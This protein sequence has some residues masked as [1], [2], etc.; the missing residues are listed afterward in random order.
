MSSDAQIQLVG[1]GGNDANIAEVDP[2]FCAQRTSLRP[3]EYAPLNG[4]LGGHFRAAFTYSNTAAKPA[5]TSPIFSLRNIDQQ[6]LLVIKRVQLWLAC[7]T[8][9][10]AAL[11]QDA[12]LWFARNFSASDS[13]GTALSI[14]A[15]G[16]LYTSKMAASIL[17]NSVI[18]QISSGDT[19]T[20]GTR[21][22]DTYPLGYAAW[23]NP[24]TAG[25]VVGPFQL[26]DT[27]P[28]DHPIVC[29]L[30]EGIVITSPIG[31]AQAA[32]VSKWS[33]FVDWAEV[34][35]Y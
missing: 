35:A 30:N 5:A 15:G 34:V 26:F 21:L 14:A 27:S 7:T 16:R 20:A 4:A 12:A 23:V 8:G 1:R 31:N 6:K 29:G 10:T 9:Y 18:G 17:G 25:A 13:G 11:A 19:L 32:G 24:A 2:T 33:V 22:L 3:I 28:G